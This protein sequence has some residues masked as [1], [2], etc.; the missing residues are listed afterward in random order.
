VAIIVSFAKLR[1]RTSGGRTAIVFANRNSPAKLRNFSYWLALTHVRIS[2][3]FAQYLR[4]ERI[5]SEF[6]Q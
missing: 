5:C 3:L 2:Q 6:D 1:I 4:I